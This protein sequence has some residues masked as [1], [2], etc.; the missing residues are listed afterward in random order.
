MGVVDHP[1]NRA[2]MPFASQA[3]RMFPLP[4]AKGSSLSVVFLP[5]PCRLCLLSNVVPLM[6]CRGRL[7]I[8]PATGLIGLPENGF[9]DDFFGCMGFIGI[10]NER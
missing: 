5:T 7:S 9:L 8:S 6:V 2:A 4:H 1:S 3:D 10:A